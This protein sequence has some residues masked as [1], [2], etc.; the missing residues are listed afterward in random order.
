MS[1]IIDRVGQRY[2]RLTVT[3]YAYKVGKRTYW[4]CE[5]DCGNSKTVSLGNL[6]RSTNSCGCIK[7]EVTGKLNYSHGCAGKGST[8]RTYRIWLNMKQRTTNPNN[9]EAEAY[10]HRGIRCCARW[11]RSFPA[12]L[13]D[14]GDCP[15]GMSLDRI[16]NDGHY[17]P[18]NCRWATAIQQANNRR[19]RRWKVRPGN[20]GQPDQLGQWLPGLSS[21]L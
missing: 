12:F 9:P 10:L 11:M 20:L 14:M 7:R 15:P 2:G 16:N 1:Q 17:E 21:L 18:S 3:A 6:G 19:P 4:V 13:E 8:S 5:C